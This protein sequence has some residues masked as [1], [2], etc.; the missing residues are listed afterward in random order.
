MH[1]CR[2]CLN[3][4]SR[5]DVLDILTDSYKGLSLE[6]AFLQTTTILAKDLE[7]NPFGCLSCVNR[8]KSAFEFRTEAISS[9]N[10]LAKRRKKILDDPDDTGTSNNPVDIKVEKVDVF[11]QDDDGYWPE[12]ETSP[13]DVFLKCELLK[14]EG[15]KV[16]TQLTRKRK[17]TRNKEKTLKGFLSKAHCRFCLKLYKTRLNVHERQHISKSNSPGFTG[18]KK[19]IYR[20]F[21]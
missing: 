2:V 6:K 13:Y 12:P 7:D 1:R 21:F 9:Q 15:E 20:D 19:T 8:L 10:W 17:Y 11:E 4:F 16:D 3:S 14:D 18:L 5:S